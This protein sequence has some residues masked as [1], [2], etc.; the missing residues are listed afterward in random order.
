MIRRPPRSTLFPYT[1][2]FRSLHLLLG[3]LEPAGR[4]A[5]AAEATIGG[6]DLGAGR[7]HGDPH[8]GMRLLHRLREYRALGH[9]EGPAFPTEAFLHPHLRDDPHELVPRLLRVVG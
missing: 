4:E 3:L 1:T 7:G 8:R 2:L 6:L 5:E 9:R